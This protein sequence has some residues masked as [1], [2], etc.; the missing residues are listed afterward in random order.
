MKVISKKCDVACVL[1]QSKFT[2][3]RGGPV[4]VRQDFTDCFAIT[5]CTIK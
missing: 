2:K 4:Q 1:W 3:V 5:V